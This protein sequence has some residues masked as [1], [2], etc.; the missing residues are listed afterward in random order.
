[1]EDEIVQNNDHEKKRDALIAA[2]S[3][4]QSASADPYS[5][6]VN[7]SDVLRH[8]C[9]QMPVLPLRGVLVLPH[10]VVQLD[11]GREKSIQAINEANSLEGKEIIIAMQKDIH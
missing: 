2:P 4:K 6:T 9:F 11:V 7:S 1:M 3:E 8:A 10:A 5:E